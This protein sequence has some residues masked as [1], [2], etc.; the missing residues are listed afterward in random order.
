VTTSVRRAADRYRSDH[1]GIST[2]HCFASGAFYDPANLSFG[3]VIAVDEHLVPGGGGFDWHAHRGVL[4]FSWVLSGALR[5]EG[6]DGVRVI[7]AGSLFRQDATGTIRHRE[8]N[9]SAS[10]S[11]HFIQTTLLAGDLGV[12]RAG[13]E[14]TGHVFVARGDW[15]VD[16]VALAPGD[17]LRSTQPVRVEGSGELL[18]ASLV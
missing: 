13:A 1:D 9:A 3:P 16:G 5:H 11:L 15:V 17:S 6:G 12:V 7:E 8:T 10:E 14:V 4:I 2:W 18:V